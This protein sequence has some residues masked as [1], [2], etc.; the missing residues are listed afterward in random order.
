MSVSTPIDLSGHYGVI[1]MDTKRTAVAIY[2]DREVEE[3]LNAPKLELPDGSESMSE[4]EILRQKIGDMHIFFEEVGKI[5]NRM[6]K[7]IEDELDGIVIVGPSPMKFQFIQLPYLR[8]LHYMAEVKHRGPLKEHP[9]SKH[10]DS[11]KTI[12]EQLKS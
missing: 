10:V 12:A 11:D 7:P 4:K 5:A 8:E 1:V 9:L 2:K 6:F 3:M